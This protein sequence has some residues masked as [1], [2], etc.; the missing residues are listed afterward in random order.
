MVGCFGLRDDHHHTRVPLDLIVEAN[1]RLDVWALLQ[2]GAL[3]EGATTRL[4]WGEK[5]LA[6]RQTRARY[7]DLGNQRSG[8]V[9]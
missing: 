8:D 4:Q 7:L 2:C 5:G 9:G 3:A 1:A 6:A